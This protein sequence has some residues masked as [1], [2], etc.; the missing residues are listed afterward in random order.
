MLSRLVHMI[1]RW[2]REERAAAAAEFAL[3]FPLLFTLMLG[4]WDIGNGILINQKAIAASQIVVDLICRQ[5]SV[6]DSELAQA[7]QAGKLAMMPYSTTPMKID[8]ASVEYD[9]NDDPQ[10]IWQEDSD[11]G[12]G[13]PDLAGRTVGLGTDGR[14]A[15]AVQ[16]T[17]N[18]DPLFSGM[19]IGPVHMKERVFS[20]GR[21]SNTVDRE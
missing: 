2:G 1:L 3:V 19:I 17:Y 12:T 10:L 16:V 21:S 20:K 11:G 18:Y 5:E 9:T 4:V 15:V 14:G 8:V 7:F 13:D 6:S